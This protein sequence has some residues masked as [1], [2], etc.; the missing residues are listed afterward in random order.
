MKISKNDME[1]AAIAGYWLQA[2]IDKH[3]WQEWITLTEIESST[4]CKCSHNN[5]ESTGFQSRK[6][7]PDIDP[8]PVSTFGTPLQEGIFF[9]SLFW[10]RK[11]SIISIDHEIVSNVAKLVA[12]HS[13]L[14]YRYGRFLKETETIWNTTYALSIVVAV[15]H[16]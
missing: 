1:W 11:P 5:Q 9:M 10:P 3:D 12:W 14:T 8:L 4:L 6:I 16:C 7:S 13:R 2:L 15:S